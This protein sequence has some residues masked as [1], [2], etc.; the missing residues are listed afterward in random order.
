MLDVSRDANVR[1]SSVQSDSPR[2]L[3]RLSRIEKLSDAGPHDYVY[4]PSAGHGVDVYV[5]DTGIYREHP[6]F[7]NRVSLGLDF[8]GEG[9]GDGNG[10]GKDNKEI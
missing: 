4:D 7:E 3:A 8:T 6:S 9:P 10:H 1:I 5:F 2:H